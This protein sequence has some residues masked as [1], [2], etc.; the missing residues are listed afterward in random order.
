MQ[1]GCQIEMSKVNFQIKPFY[2]TVN[3]IKTI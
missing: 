3:I 2:E 1:V